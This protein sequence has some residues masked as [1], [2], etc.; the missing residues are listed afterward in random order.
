VK[1]PSNRMFP[2]GSKGYEDILTAW[3]QTALAMGIEYGIWVG[4]QTVRRTQNDQFCLDSIF[5]TI[6]DHEFANLAELK[7]ALCNKSML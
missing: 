7:K 3:E 1:I 6:E 4:V 5:F 2:T